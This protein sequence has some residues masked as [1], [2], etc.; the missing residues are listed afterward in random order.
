MAAI[1]MSNGV[2][3]RFVRTAHDAG[4]S[5][6]RCLK[7]GALQASASYPKGAKAGANVRSK[8]VGRILLKLLS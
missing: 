6:R 2:R 7:S 1:D 8:G 4:N 5:S 3:K